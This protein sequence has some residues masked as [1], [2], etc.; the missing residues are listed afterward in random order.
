MGGATYKIRQRDE[1][2]VERPCEIRDY[3]NRNHTAT[4]MLGDSAVAVHRMNAMRQS[5]KL[6]TK[7]SWTETAPP[8]D[9]DHHG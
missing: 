5:L 3:L 4:A 1:D 6:C 8:D 2:G 7:F 9:S